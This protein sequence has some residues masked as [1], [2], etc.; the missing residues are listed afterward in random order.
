MDNRVDRL[1]S[2]E[3]A[4]F[5]HMYLDFYD[6]KEPPFSITPDPS[7]L[8][9]SST[10]QSVLERILFGITNRMGFILLIGE[11]GT[12]KTTICRSIL[13]T[14]EGKAETVY[15]I[16]PSLSGKEL[17][18]TVLD[19]LGIDYPP[20]ASKKDL[21]ECLNRFLLLTGEAKPVVIIID[22]AQTMS[23]ETLEDLRLLSNLE[24]DKT[25]LVQM[26]L[27]GQ[28]E[29]ID[30]LN[31]PEMRQ[32]RQRIAINCR[33]EF[34]RQRE[35]EQ[36]ISRRLF[37]AGDKGRIRYTRRGVRLIYQSSGGIPRLI[38]RICDYALVAGYVA[39]DFNIEPTH[40]RKALKEIGYR[41]VNGGYFSIGCKGFIKN[42]MAQWLP[43]LI[44]IVFCF[45]VV[46]GYAL[47]EPIS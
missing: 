29:L 17:I 27:V 46:F 20:N 18:S 34:L 2:N 9:L 11:V 26:L 31:R 6:L 8:Y 38:N 7:F 14:L 16:N 3:Q 13:D 36:Y 21:I 1:C 44:L 37:I 23:L 41:R 47:F 33:L 10:H 40:I 45:M 43:L 28:P 39:N 30:I 22:D 24:T 35:I 25:K 15:V 32:L 42:I 5:D 4:T 19:D 12:G